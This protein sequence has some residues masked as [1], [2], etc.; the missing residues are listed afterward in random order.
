MSQMKQLSTTL[1]TLTELFTVTY[2]L[3][4]RMASVQNVISSHFQNHN[5]MQT[6]PHQMHY[7]YLFKKHGNRISDPSVFIR[8]SR[9]CPNTGIERET[10][11]TAIHL[12]S[13]TTPFDS[14]PNRV[15]ESQEM[16]RGNRVT[17]LE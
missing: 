13:L 4:L 9:R 15:L 1:Q 10:V 6:T 16:R 12:N 5:V 17:T 7:L 14:K 8:R 2:S 11:P 3:L